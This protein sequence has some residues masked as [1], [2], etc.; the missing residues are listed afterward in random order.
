MRGIQAVLLRSSDKLPLGE[1]TSGI[2]SYTGDDITNSSM[3]AEHNA[4][5]EFLFGVDGQDL[6]LVDVWEV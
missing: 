3:T 4:H 2:I 5:Y 6:Y 1:A